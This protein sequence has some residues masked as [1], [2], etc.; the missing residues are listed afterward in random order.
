MGWIF[1][2]PDYPRMALIDRKD[3]NADPGSSLSSD[4]QVSLLTRSSFP[5]VRFQHKHYLPLT[6]GLGLVAPALVGWSYGD[7]LGG[8]IWGGVSRLFDT[9]DGAQLTWSC[10]SSLVSSSGKRPRTRQQ[11]QVLTIFD[12]R[13]HCTFFI[14]SLAH[15][16]GDQSY[17]ED[18]TARGNFVRVLIG[19]QVCELTAFFAVPGFVH[20]RRG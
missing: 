13:R 14:N 16:L 11:E 10:R 2:K 5:V 17:S 19:V 6:L 9:R 1:R 12:S 4:L 15:Y 8:F 3:L 20:R 18:V 7:A